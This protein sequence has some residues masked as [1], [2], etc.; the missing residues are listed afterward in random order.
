M[1][2]MTAYFGL[3]DVDQAQP[4]Q[5]VGQLALNKGCSVVGI[6][7]GAAK[8]DS[9]VRKGCFDACIDCKGGSVKDGLKAHCPDRVDVYFDNV[10]G[11]ILDL[12]QAAGL[13]PRAH[14]AMDQK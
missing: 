10:G 9:A 8:C 6:V 1:P 14:A 2:G 7:G 4:S 5:T 13:E 11:E 3:L 12:P